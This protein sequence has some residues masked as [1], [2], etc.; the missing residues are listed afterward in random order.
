VPALKAGRPETL[1]L[2]GALAELWAHGMPVDWA[3]ILGESGG[4]QVGLPTYPFQ[5]RRY[6]LESSTTPQSSAEGR[7]AEDVRQGE[8]AG[9]GFWDAVEREDLAGLLDTLGVDDEQ[10]RSS[11]NALLPSLSAWRRRSRAHSLIGGWCY[12]VH[13]QPMVVSS[14]QA[15][16][17]TWLVV[18][19]ATLGEDRWITE[20]IGALRERG[21]QVLPLEI[22]ELED[23]REE[24]ARRLHDTI[25]APLDAGR[26]D[27]VISLLA[28]QEGRHP[29]C[30]GVPIGLAGTTALVQALG[31]VE[32][33]APLWLLT[34]GAVP[35]VP[36]DMIRSPIQAQV[37]GFGMAVGL[38]HPERWGGVVDLPDSFDE[39]VGSLLVGILAGSGGEDQLAV[40]GA[41][42]FVRRLV[43]SPRGEET[44]AGWSS[45]TGTVLIT[46]GTGGLGAHV[47]RWLARSGAEHLLLLSGRGIGAPGA[48]ELREELVGLGVEVT[49]AACDVADR[50]QLEALLEPL[51]KH[52]PLSMVVHAAGVGSHGPIAS[53]T[54]DDFERTLSAK[55]QGALN[56]DALTESLDLSAFVLFSSIAGTLGAGLQ[57]PYAAANA[58]LDAVAVGRRARGLPATSMAWGP[59]DG[60]G[61]ATREG[62]SEVL[63]RRG[64]ECIAPELAI[65]ALQGALLRD[66]TQL[67]MADIRWETYARLFTSARS[68]PLIEDLP[69][70]QAALAATATGEERA[71]G[72]ELRKRMGEV[73][74][75]ERRELLLGLVRAE[76]ARVMGHGS[77][78]TV[79]PK[80]AFKELGFDSLMAVELRNRLELAIGLELSTTLVFD[81]PTPMVLVDHLLAELTDGGVLA[82][83]SAESELVGLE[84]A[85]V[86]LED[87]AERRRVRARLRALLAGL[88]NGDNGRSLG[89]E[90]GAVTVVERMQSA[91]D[92]EIFDFID[93]QLGSD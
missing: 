85:L 10:R 60:E 25:E 38:E 88:D 17:G 68:R 24:L 71:A 21:V 28:L 48:E 15:L 31:D 46:G 69:E 23:A 84:R 33:T 80:R 11:L 74:A 92:E 1:S 40:R 61:M 83:V 30:G 35:A 93:Q 62:A 43:R 66:E 90:Q 9:E 42:V 5:R 8:L 16:S 20:L 47:A 29:V 39:R 81:Y 86:S 19:P 32:L 37:W 44:T 49:I 70:V 26:V 50:A 12:R 51:A 57:A 2:V 72:R 53:L 54:V 14:A 55:V 34:R 18:M 59:W 56:L 87:G 77:L 73:S 13:W 4:R 76:V 7:T 65:E 58:C 67:A 79:D 27:G 75:R 3:A 82:G 6:W 63:R 91:S 64:L 36:S 89:E 52:R 22:D 45:P 41:G 78:E